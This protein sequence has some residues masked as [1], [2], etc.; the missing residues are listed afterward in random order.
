MFPLVIVKSFGNEKP[1]E[2]IKN[3]LKVTDQQEEQLEFKFDSCS[4]RAYKCDVVTKYYETQ[5]AL[6]GFEEDLTSIPSDVLKNIEAALFYFDSDDRSFLTKVDSLCSFVK[7]N[8]IQV[9]ALITRNISDDDL[10]G[11]TYGELKKR[12][13][14]CFD[15][16]DLSDQNDLDLNGCGE[17]TELLDLLKNCVWSNVKHS[18]H[19]NDT[20]NESSSDIDGIEEQLNSFEELLKKV[21]N[22]KETSKTLSREDVLNNAEKLAELFVNIIND[23]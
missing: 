5:I 17:Y 10:N 18:Q 22:F 13:K 19:I 9:A 12:C 11:I 16:V 20:S 4:L 2:I 23:E 6:F 15:V 1:E 14:L 21:Q 8:K 3:I 7:C